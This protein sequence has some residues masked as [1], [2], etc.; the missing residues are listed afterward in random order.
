M[1]PCQVP[2]EAGATWEEQQNTLCFVHRSQG[3][4]FV[5]SWLPS[6][7]VEWKNEVGLKQIAASGETCGLRLNRAIN[8]LTDMKRARGRERKAGRGIESK[9]KSER[10]V[11]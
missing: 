2:P 1:Q 6:E 7:G 10:T 11:A 9:T 3:L 4:I 8:Q 5:G